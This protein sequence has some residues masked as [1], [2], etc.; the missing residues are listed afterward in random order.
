ML[1]EIY[2]YFTIDILY[3]WVNI[4]VL[5]FWLIL[6]FFPRSYLSRYFVTSVF[7]IF[8]LGGTYIFVLYKSYL[9]SFD[10]VGNFNLY[11]GIDEISDLF[12]DKNFL[13]MF[14]IHFI[15]IN[16]FVG[17]WIV[18]DSQKFMI[19]K[20]LLSVPLVITYLIGPLGL[21]VY[22]LIRIFYAKNINLYE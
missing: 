14:W 5:P 12:T 4:G 9:N 16:L 10:F 2:N 6:I 11:I 1:E 15:S 21:F 20:F 8:I 13:I 19:N 18:K 7:P 17:G 3:N 22:W